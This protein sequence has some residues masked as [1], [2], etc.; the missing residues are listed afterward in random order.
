LQAL[1]KDFFKDRH[2]TIL[3]Y[4]KALVYNQLYFNVM[5]DIDPH[6]YIEK[7]VRIIEVF[8]DLD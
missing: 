5:K 6:N 1:V 4:P 8:R 2:S 3:E 7:I